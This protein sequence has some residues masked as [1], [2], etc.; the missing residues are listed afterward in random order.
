MNVIEI[1]GGTQNQRKHVESMVQFCINILMPR[2]STLDIEVKLTAP[3][4]A[5]GYCTQHMVR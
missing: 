1:I 3:Q 4:G 2:I 5:M